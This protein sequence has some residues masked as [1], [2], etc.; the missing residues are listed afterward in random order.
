MK[1]VGSELVVPAQFSGGRLERENAYLQ[2]EIHREHNF[3][4]MVGSSPALLAALDADDPV[5]RGIEE[6][7]GK[8]GVDPAA[9]RKTIDEYN[10]GIETKNDPL[11]KKLLGQR[12]PTIIVI[13]MV[14]VLGAVEA[15]GHAEHDLLLVEAAIEDR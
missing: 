12:V 1:I 2:E 15:P 10:A 6:L 7:A 3:V 11:G 4:E 14:V 13:P 9:F 5:R 8:I